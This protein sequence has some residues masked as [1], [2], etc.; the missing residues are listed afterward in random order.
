[1]DP[2]NFSLIYMRFVK[3]LSHFCSVFEKVGSKFLVR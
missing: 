1:M 2:Q 3:G